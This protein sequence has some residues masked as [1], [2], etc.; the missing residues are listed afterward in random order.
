LWP[1]CGQAAGRSIDVVESSLVDRWAL[2]R[3]APGDSNPEPAACHPRHLRGGEDLV[4]VHRYAIKD[5]A[6]LLALQGRQVGPLT[7]I[8][9][10]KGIGFMAA[11]LKNV[12]VLPITLLGIEPVDVSSDWRVREMRLGV[13]ADEGEDALVHTRSFAPQHLNPG[14]IADVVIVWVALPCDSTRLAD[15]RVSGPWR[16]ESSTRS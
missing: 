2:D 16:F 3:W 7:G 9:P 12:S 8:D 11:S 13:L 4:P 1:S 15:G 14:E 6:G 10:E 5:E